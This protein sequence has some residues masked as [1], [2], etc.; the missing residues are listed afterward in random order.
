LAVVIFTETRLS[1]VF[2]IDLDLNQDARGFFAR[3]FCQ[4]EFTEHGLL[5]HYPQC[6]LS[7][8]RDRGTLRGLHFNRTPYEEAK[9]VRCQAGTIYDVVVD[10]RRGSK[11]LGQWLGVELS[12][13]NRRQLYIPKG[14]AHGILTLTSHTEIFYQMSDFYVPGAGLGLR[15]DDPGIGIQWPA[16]PRVISERDRNYPD[17]HPEGE[18]D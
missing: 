4:R 16:A 9:L 3:S 15:Y 17:W 1:G 7:Y 12:S 10:L 14:C 13:Q 6:N 2:I 8:N 5:A 18:D 11:T